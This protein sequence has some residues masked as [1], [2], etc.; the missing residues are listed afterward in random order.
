MKETID[1]KRSVSCVLRCKN[2]KKI[3]HRKK[4][5]DNTTK[6]RI[7]AHLICFNKKDFL[8]AKKQKVNS[9]II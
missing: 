2:K 9:H 6:K 4:N 3:R 8:K 7:F 5:F 1:K